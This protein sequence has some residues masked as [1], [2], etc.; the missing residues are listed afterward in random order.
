MLL[1][2]IFS[3]SHNVFKRPFLQGRWKSGLYVKELRKFRKQ[4]YMPKQWNKTPKNVDFQINEMDTRH[5]VK[6]T[7]LPKFLG[8]KNHV[9][10]K[11]NPAVQG[12]FHFEPAEG[13]VPLQISINVKLIDS[14]FSRVPPHILWPVTSPPAWY[15]MQ[16][17]NTLSCSFLW[18]CQ[19]MNHQ[20]VPY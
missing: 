7:K 13:I 11:E 4:R 6:Q 17:F 5:L 3:F 8:L 15:M 12:A 1:T 14:S 18:T 9:S 10:A 20:P 2:S 16:T 19:D